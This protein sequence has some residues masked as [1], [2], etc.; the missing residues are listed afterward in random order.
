MIDGWENRDGHGWGRCTAYQGK[1]PPTHPEPIDIQA[2]HGAIATFCENNNNL[3]QTW[4]IKD[5][6]CMCQIVVDMH[7]A[8][9]TGYGPTY[10]AAQVDAIENLIY[11]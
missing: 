11:S 5:G 4:K 9:A 1:I 6:E 3:I 7:R 2:V 10:L 8:I